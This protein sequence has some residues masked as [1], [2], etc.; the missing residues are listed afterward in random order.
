MCPFALNEAKS[1]MPA[2][3]M[4]ALQPASSF[5]RLEKYR[6]Q[7][8]EIRI[9]LNKNKKTTIC[10][11]HSGRR[12]L[13]KWKKEVPKKV[14][15]FVVVSIAGSSQL[16][17]C[18]KSH[19]AKIKQ[20]Q[21]NPFFWEFHHCDYPSVFLTF[22]FYFFLALCAWNVNEAYNIYIRQQTVVYLPPP[23][24]WSFFSTRS[25]TTLLSANSSSNSSH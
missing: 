7:V 9:K 22:L 5:P 8:T 18:S 11:L 20:K 21:K 13:A 24:V 12:R 16:A 6:K 2:T 15:R 25:S 4:A 10:L 23:N 17:H 19:Q 3:S 14:Y 1:I